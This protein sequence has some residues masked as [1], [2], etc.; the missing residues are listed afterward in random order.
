MN[1]KIFALLTEADHA[2]LRA[3]S[4][5]RVQTPQP[6]KGQYDPFDP[7]DK[8]IVRLASWMAERRSGVPGS[9][10]DAFKYLVALADEDRLRTW[11]EDRPEWAPELMKLL[12]HMR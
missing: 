1:E 11:L 7:D 8:N 6:P 10:I 9:V 4:R 3:S 2:E 5:H 12:E